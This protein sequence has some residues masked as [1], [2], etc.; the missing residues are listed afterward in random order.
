MT[1][2]LENEAREWIQAVL[3]VT[4]GDDL[5]EELKTGD[6]LC[7]VVNKIKPNTIA[8]WP[9]SKF[10][11]VCLECVGMYIDGCRKIGLPEHELFSPDDIWSDN[12]LYWKAV[13][14][15]IH[16][17]GRA[18][19]KVPGFEGPHLG[20]KLATSNARTFTPEVLRGGAVDAVSTEAKRAGYSMSPQKS[21][22]YQINKNT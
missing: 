11:F 1:A 14:I 7:Q 21:V 19:Q 12:A 18:A 17:L 9:K 6:I 10:K 16:A 3:G 4:L 13:L 22:K 8:S 2:E 20:A 15:N 5:R